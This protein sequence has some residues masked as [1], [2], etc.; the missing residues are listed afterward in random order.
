MDVEQLK[1]RNKRSLRR[2]RGQSLLEFALLL[3]IMGGM[4][5][6]LVQINMAINV[7]IV[8]QK[9]TRNHL[10]HLFF[11][12]RYYPE[13]NQAKSINGGIAGRFWIGMDDRVEP[14]G[15]KEVNPHPI[16]VKIGTRKAGKDD[17][18]EAKIRQNVRIRVTS[19]TCTAPFGFKFDSP[20]TEGNLEEDSFSNSKQVF[21]AQ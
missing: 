15:G 7:S 14:D 18:P 3:P 11:N 10:Y 4:V 6:L 20:F 5:L 17:D 9:Y 8:S 2:Q 12:H 1:S 19:F 16:K 21:C 13:L